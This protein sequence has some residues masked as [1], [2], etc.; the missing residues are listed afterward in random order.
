MERRIATEERVENQIVVA[1]ARAMRNTS[2]YASDHSLVRLNI[3]DA[4]ATISRM[5]EKKREFVLKIV[6]GEIVANDLPLFDP[7]TG[8][9]NLVGACLNRDIESITFSSGLSTEEVAALVNLL[10]A[11]SE[12]I[13][14]QG[15]AATS[16]SRRGASHIKVEKL[17]TPGSDEGEATESGHKTYASALDVLRA[18]ARRARM[19]FSP[20][21]GTTH[22]AVSDLVDSIML[23]QAAMLG[24]VSV[25]G[26]DEYTFTHAL[27]ICIL[28]LQLGHSL[29]LERPQL[30]ELG[31]CAMLHDIGKIF[32]PLPILRKPAALTQKEFDIIQQHPIHGALLLCRHE[33]APAMAPLVAFEHH[34]HFDLSGYPQTNSRRH[35]NFYSLMVGPADV[36]DALT[37]D[38]PYRPALPPKQALEVMQSQSSYFEPRL[39]ARFTEMLGKYPAGSLLRLNDG[40]LAVV[41][42]PN[43]CNAAMPFVRILEFEDGSPRLLEEEINL[44]APDPAT[45]RPRLCVDSVVDP[46]PMEL[47]ICGLLGGNLYCTE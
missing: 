22:A 37:T 32:I 13:S 14:Q 11:D 30:Q 21:S 42:K 45:G 9:A 3:E 19:G 47:D 10:A 12:E 6:E 16:L 24:M 35:L 29:G 15:G 41:T 28:C 4:A 27:H 31:V 25:K 18:A 8:T 39:L 20:E 40:R 33:E 23:E 34:L 1:L 36:Y 26:R 5:L 44:A 43:P 17:I 2:F 46:T 7:G 38:R